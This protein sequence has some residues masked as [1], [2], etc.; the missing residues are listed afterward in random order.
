MLPAAGRSWFPLAPVPAVGGSSKE[1]VVKTPGR[2]ILTSA[3]RL[4]EGE[5]KLK[6]TGD[7]IWIGFLKRESSI[8]LRRAFRFWLKMRF[9]KR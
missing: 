6:E 4:V 2:S 5:D 7:P 3:E 8:L 1:N 9:R